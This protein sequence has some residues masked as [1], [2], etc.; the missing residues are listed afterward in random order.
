MRYVSLAFAL[1]S[2]VTAAL[3]AAAD[4]L[5]DAVSRVVADYITPAVAG[6]S[7]QAQSLAEAAGADCTASNLVAP[8][9][10]AFDAWLRVEPFALSSFDAGG[11]AKAISFWPDKKG[12]IPRALAMMIDDQDPVV[13][14]ATEFADV[15]IAARG[16][17]ALEYMLFDP[18]FAAY[19]QDSYSCDLVQAQTAD[20][21]AMAQD[22]HQAWFGLG[23]FAELLETAGEE[24]NPRYFTPREAVQALYT[25][26]TASL[27]HDRD[28]RLG[29]PMGSFDKPRPIR[30]EARRSE[31]SARNLIGSLHAIGE[32]ADT[33]APNG[34]P[35]TVAALDEAVAQIT[36][37]DDPSFARSDDLGQR[38]KMEVI[39]QR[40]KAAE[41]AAANEIGVALGVSAGFNA[42]D[43]D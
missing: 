9:H 32:L 25:T 31:R 30:A 5:H 10:E 4:P 2:S 43:G 42:G 13:S 29:R 18:A 23:G 39:Q 16:L 7:E 12:M 22:V 34:A 6:F 20:L 35:Q 38:F 17:F 15:S 27:E 3:P 14:D 8:Y 37:L 11:H 26:V 41:H 19:S 24:G 21:A 36:A 1:V 40:I 33:L 28:V